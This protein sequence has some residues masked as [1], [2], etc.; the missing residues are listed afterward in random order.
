MR[1][2]ILAFYALDS[3]LETPFYIMINIQVFMR[4]SVMQMCCVGCYGHAH[5]MIF[6]RSDFVGIIKDPIASR[7]IGVSAPLLRDTR[8]ISKK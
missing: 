1:H 8:N 7:Q 5:I 3:T 4:V 6:A 2:N